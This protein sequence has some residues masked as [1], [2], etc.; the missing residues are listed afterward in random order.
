MLSLRILPPFAS[1]DKAAITSL[2]HYNMIQKRNMGVKLGVFITLKYPQES[3][4]YPNAWNYCWRIRPLLYMIWNGSIDFAWHKPCRCWNKNTVIGVLR[5]LTDGTCNI[6]QSASSK[7]NDTNIGFLEISMFDAFPDLSVLKEEGQG[8][9]WKRRDFVT[10]C[11]SIISQTNKIKSQFSVQQ[12]ALYCFQ[13]LCVTI[14]CW[15]HFL[16]NKIFSYK[17]T[18]SNIVHFA[19]LSVVIWYST[20]HGMS[21]IQ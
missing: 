21:C 10:P 16:I 7:N 20:M 6:L 17:V 12:S 13:I 5:F 14:Y 2:S 15:A 11:G 19:G 8:I 4:C 1:N 18:G 9:A 3:I